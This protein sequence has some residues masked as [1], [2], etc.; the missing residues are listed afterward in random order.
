MFGVHGNLSF[1]F[2]GFGYFVSAVWAWQLQLWTLFLEW[3]ET[4]YVDDDEEDN[5]DNDDAGDNDDDDHD[6]ISNN[7]ND[8][9]N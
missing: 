6:D 4:S 9:D 2:K 3:L 1:I 7:D 8:E 5:A